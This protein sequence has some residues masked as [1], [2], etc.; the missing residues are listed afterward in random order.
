MNQHLLTLAGL[1]S[2]LLVNQTFC[3]MLNIKNETAIKQKARVLYS[4][5]SLC[6]DDSHV[7]I[8][9]EPGETKRINARCNLAW[10][11]MDNVRGT[12]YITRRNSDRKMINPLNGLTIK[13]VNGKTVMV[14]N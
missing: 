4:R 12:A 14:E 11:D 7:T 9:L 13:T 3:W 10:I 5:E 2:L 1:L 8:E 6:P